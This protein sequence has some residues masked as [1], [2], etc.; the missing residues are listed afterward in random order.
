MVVAGRC[1]VGLRGTEE[2]WVALQ[3]IAVVLD[4]M[5]KTPGGLTAAEFGE[6]AWVVAQGSAPWLISAT[7]AIK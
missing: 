5:K 1:T 2:G 3:M 7:S 6:Q 4:E